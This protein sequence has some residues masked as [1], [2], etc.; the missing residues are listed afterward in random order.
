[1]RIFID[2]FHLVRIESYDYIYH[3]HIPDNELEWVKNEGLNQYFKT[4]KPI[5]LHLDDHI[6]VNDVKYPL[7]LGIVTLSK[8]FEERFRYDGPLGAIYSKAS[9]TFQVFS[10]VAKEMYV[11]IDDASFPMTYEEP[12]YTVTVCGDFSGKRYHYHVRL[13]DTFYDVID[14]YAMGAALDGAYVID[15]DQVEKINPTPIK[16]KNYVDAVIY[17]GHVRDLTINLDVEHK[18]L[19]LGLTEPSKKLKGSVLNYIKKLGVTHLQLLPVFDFEGVDDVD[20]TKLYNWGYNPSLYFSLEGW[21]A[22]DPKNPYDRIHAFR[23]VIN[24]AHRLKLGVNMDVVYNHVYQHL[25]FPYEKLVP[26]YFYRHNN[27]HHMTD[28]SYCGND[29]ETRNYMVRKLIT[30]SLIH[31]AT[32]YQIDGFRFDL[33]GLMDIETM[34]HIERKLKAINPHIMLYGEGWHMAGELPH[35]KKA[36]LPNQKSFTGYAHFND[37]FRNTMKGELHGP[38]LGFTMGN[39]SQCQ[40]VMDSIIGSPQLFEN[41]NQSINYVEC[42][43]NMTYYDKMLLT[44]GYE[45]ESFKI[46]Q[47]F[48]NHLI[49]I[50]QGI[51]FYHA[52]QE[53]YRSKKGV[54]NSYNAPD[55]INQIHWKPEDQSVVK[56]RKLLKLRKKFKLYRQTSYNE[57]IKIEKDNHMLLYKLEDKKNILIHY[58]KNYKGIEKLPTH[59]GTL[60]FPSQPALLE[61]HDIYVDEPGI[62]IIHIKK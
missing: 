2:E 51:P 38:G 39:R 19:F 7:E 13:V 53:F 3:I 32:M 40:K 17:E 18:G 50:S 16:L 57:N 12:I 10:P 42:H 44:T 6:Y 59:E 11:V 52:G 26:G 27:K 24:E 43:D 62:Y 58:I 37:T 15:F 35:A 22:K 28:S 30:D 61:S 25:T 33:M 5:R 54:E 56:L 41:Q 55:E 31:F 4:K 20:K 36:S 60:I 45:Q 48:A 8:A 14:P 46:N 21:Y 23:K 29:I 34:L 9:T 49:A 47:D 1:M